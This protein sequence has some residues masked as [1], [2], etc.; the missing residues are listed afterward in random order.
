MSGFDWEPV[1]VPAPVPADWDGWAE[2]PANYDGHSKILPS[3]KDA[4]IVKMP[5]VGGTAEPLAR[6]SSKYVPMP[7]KRLLGLAEEAGDSIGYTV[8]S[9]REFRNGKTVVVNLVG[10]TSEWPWDEKVKDSEVQNRIS[11]LNSHDGTSKLKI[12]PM[13]T[14]LICLNQMPSLAGRAN[15]S[16]RHSQVIQNF[17]LEP[18]FLSMEK[19]KEVLLWSRTAPM[20]L[21]DGINFLKRAMGDLSDKTEKAIK[22]ATQH[23]TAPEQ[24]T[25]WAFLQAVTLA[26][27]TLLPRKST[28]AR[29]EFGGALTL[30]A[31]RLVERK[32]EAA[33]TSAWMKGLNDSHL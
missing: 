23:P 9:V 8:D 12:W 19:Y 13:F 26:D 27:Q 31:T 29:A 6:V 25:V 1:V 16:Y 28:A 15:W 33:Q 7:N 14:S 18:A 11:I 17:S 5:T 30:S 32:A 2:D 22:D 3:D 21:R 4:Y 24:G 20:D 10:E